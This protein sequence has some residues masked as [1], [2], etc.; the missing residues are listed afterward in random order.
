M[1]ITR[2]RAAALLVAAVLAAGC[3][4]NRGAQVATPPLQP[5]L[6]ASVVAT[7]IATASSTATPVLPATPTLTP[8]ATPSPTASP[9]ATSTPTP[10]PPWASLPL[11]ID[12]AHG[13]IFSSAMMGRW[14][15]GQTVVLSAADGHLLATYDLSGTLALDAVHSWLYAD[16]GSDGLVIADLGHCP[17]NT[18]NM[19]T[20]HRVSMGADGGNLSARGGVRALGPSQCGGVRSTQRSTRW[21]TVWTSCVSEG[22]LAT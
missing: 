3:S 20:N 15:T 8:S 5:T 22:G 11:L 1:A 4:L 18:V 7:A 10:E 16:Q 13:R 2:T 14:P 19:N 9:S 21:P 6:P 12:G 17:S